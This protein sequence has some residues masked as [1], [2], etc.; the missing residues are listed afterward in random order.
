MND[1]D[2]QSRLYNMYP[3]EVRTVINALECYQSRMGQLDPENWS[4]EDD[5]EYIRV[6]NLLIWFRDTLFGGE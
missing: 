5:K 3:D 6:N 4:F 1:L 2:E